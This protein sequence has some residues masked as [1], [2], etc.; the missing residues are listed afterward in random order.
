MGPAFR[1]LERSTH[2]NSDESYKQAKQGR[3]GK[4][5]EKDIDPLRREDAER[6]EQSPIGIP[7]A[8]PF[9]DEIGQSKTR[10]ARAGDGDHAVQPEHITV[11]QPVAQIPAGGQ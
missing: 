7:E 6:A 11:L 1:A 8:A 2:A 4:S 9:V 5:R 3:Y 10:M